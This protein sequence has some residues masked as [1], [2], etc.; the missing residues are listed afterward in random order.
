MTKK[1]LIKKSAKYRRVHNVRRKSFPVFNISIKKR[2]EMI[3]TEY[4]RTQF[5]AMTSRIVFVG[6]DVSLHT[7][8]INVI[9]PK[10]YFIKCY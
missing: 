8:S 1:L 5:A 2:F 6:P 10:K 3:S 4:L 7:F 9:I